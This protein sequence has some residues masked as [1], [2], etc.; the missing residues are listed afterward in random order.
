MFFDFQN[1]EISGC[2]YDEFI[3]T[4]I[5]EQANTGCMLSYGNNAKLDKWSV[6]W[7]NTIDNSDYESDIS[8][9]FF[10]FDSHIVLLPIDN[11]ESCLPVLPEI[12]N[13]TTSEPPTAI[14]LI[15]VFFVSII[16]LRFVRKR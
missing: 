10:D 8:C 5:P 16:L 3:V 4:K 1:I 7:C 11:Q 12:D 13:P 2:P 14:I 9:P 15:I 6:D